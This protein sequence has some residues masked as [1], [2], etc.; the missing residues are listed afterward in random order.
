MIL[1]DGNNF[2][3]LTYFDNNSENYKRNSIQY[4]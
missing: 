4:V 1:V 2:K 3:P